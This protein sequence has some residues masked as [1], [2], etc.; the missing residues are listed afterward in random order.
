M[1]EDNILELEELIEEHEKLMKKSFRMII[2]FFTMFLIDIVLF[3]LLQT[4]KFF[5]FNLT[6]TFENTPSPL[7]AEIFSV[8]FLVIVIMGL[9]SYLILASAYFER[10][11]QDLERQIDSLDSFRK[12]YSAADIFSIVPLFLI[13]VMIVNGFFFSFAQVDGISMQ[14][15]FCDSDAV[16]IKYVDQYHTDDIVILEEG[17]IYLIKRLIAVPGDKLYV[18]ISGVYVNDVL[19]ESTIGNNSVGYD[20]IVPEGY[21]YVMGDNRENS[22]DS[23]YFG[24]VSEENMLG[25]VVLKMSNSTCDLT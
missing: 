14:P 13:I 9:I 7:V 17:N 23:R 4:N 11:N 8:F 18:D 15:T 21:Y 22:Q 25:I 20:L 10:R 19:I 24:L 5:I 2:S 12:K 6:R 3:I 1:T 16:V